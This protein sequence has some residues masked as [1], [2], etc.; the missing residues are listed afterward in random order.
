MKN[1][2]F[3]LIICFGNIQKVS[4]KWFSGTVC[5]GSVAYGFECYEVSWIDEIKNKASDVYDDY[6]K[7]A[8]NKVKEKAIETWENIKKGTEDIIK[9][10]GIKVEAGWNYIKDQFNTEDWEVTIYMK[11]SPKRKTFGIQLDIPSGGQIESNPINMLDY[12]EN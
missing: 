5:I 10:T 2:L 8:A 9:S 1:F 12:R 4:G 7:P 6:I 11:F 3:V